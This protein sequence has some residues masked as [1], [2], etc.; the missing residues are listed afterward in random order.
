MAQIPAVPYRVVKG[1]IYNGVQFQ[2]N[3][4]FLPDMF[5]V[6]SHKMNSLI[7]NRNLNLATSYTQK[8]AEASRSRIEKALAESR[9]G[10]VRKNGEKEFSALPKQEEPAV[11]EQAPEESK[12]PEEPKEAEEGEADKAVEE[13]APAPTRRRRR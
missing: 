4:L 3:D 5:N 2:P 1:F 8:E 11:E 10:M 6:P 13:E 12:E 7:S 9:R